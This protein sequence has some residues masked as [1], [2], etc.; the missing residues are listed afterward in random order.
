MAT[1]V[2]L[3][4]SD[5]FSALAGA[6]YDVIVTNPPYVGHEEMR[7]LPAEYL[8]EPRLALES[9]AD[10]LEAIT[11]ILAAAADHLEPQGVLVAEVGNSNRL[12]QQ[13]YP[14]VPFL[15]LTT[16]AGDDSVF[17]LTAEQL[18]AHRN[19][20]ATGTRRFT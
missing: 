3:L 8:R 10:G 15:W 17:L 9:G 19:R 5:L 13:T 7:A 18:F 6:R 11:R 4:H 20:F 12:L 16:E 1:R 14:D 2:R